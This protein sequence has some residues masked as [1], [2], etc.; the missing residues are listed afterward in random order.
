LV[1]K[2]RHHTSDEVAESTGAGSPFA[3]FEG[4]T[5]RAASPADLESIR[6]L[7]ARCIDEVCSFE[8]DRD[9]IAAWLGA[10][11]SDRYPAML[12]THHVI[13]AEDGGTVV[14]FGMADLES[15]S[16]NAIYVAPS[17][18]REGIG[19][20]LVAAIEEAAGDAGTNRLDLNATLGAVSFYESL[21]YVSDGPSHNVL[22]SGVSLPCVA[23]HRS[24][25]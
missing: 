3:G 10:L 5:I 12:A 7:H 14:G 19:S 2:S 20:A 13:V 8:Y 23:M 11:D 6:S 15:A 16:L 9:Q 18:Q 22:P 21:G 1:R 25:R 17:R 4:P 24:F